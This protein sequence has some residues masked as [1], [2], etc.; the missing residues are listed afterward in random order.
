MPLQR[1]ERC[2][3]RFDKG[4]NNGSGSV[5]RARR[6]GPPE[7]RRNEETPT[8]PDP[9]EIQQQIEDTRAELASTIDAIADRVNPKKVVARGVESVKGKVEDLM[10]SGTAPSGSP[11][12]LT[13]PG[14]G[15][16]PLPERVKAQLREAKRTRGRSVRWDRVAMVGG[17]IVVVILLL[18]RRGD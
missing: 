1:P 16:Q 2:V 11:A 7:P 15:Q 14:S 5:P 13:G 8:V 6:K 10:S 9:S 4:H 18:R 17:A 12:A 3:I